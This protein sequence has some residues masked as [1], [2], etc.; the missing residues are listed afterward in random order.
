MRRLGIDMTKKINYQEF[1]S[2]LK[3][4]NPESMIKA[5]GQN[6]D[7]NKLMNILHMQG[8]L[9]KSIRDAEKGAFPLGPLISFKKALIRR[10]T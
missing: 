4:S 10:K 6:L 3:P 1:A 2:L 7:Q 9:E 8:E 5:F